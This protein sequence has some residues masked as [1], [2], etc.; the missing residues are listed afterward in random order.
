MPVRTAAERDARKAH[1]VAPGTGG[2][3]T[4]ALMIATAMQAFDATIANVALP[5]LEASLSGGIELGAWVM[6]SYLCASAVVA[7]LTGWVRHRYGARRLFPAAIALYALVSLGCSIA[8]SA[9]VLILF[10]ILQG[11]AGGLILPLSQAILLDIHPERE[12][13]RVLGMWG[14]TV[15]IGPILGPVLGGV[16]TDLASWRW[17]FAVNLPLAALA[18][19]GLRGALPPSDRAERAPIDWIGM[20]LLTVGVG[21]LEFGILRSIGI[22]ELLSPETI[23]E[24]M[25]GVFALSV[26]TFRNRLFNSRRPLFQIEIFSDRNFLISASY[27]FVISGLLFATIVFLP[28]LAQGP[29]GFS[30]TLAGLTIVPRGVGTMLMMLASGRLMGVVG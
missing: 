21:M 19:F 27:N 17:I 28:A 8:P 25:I 4:M 30:S 14:A 12:H 3:A 15:M 9:E 13:G 7:P 6:T 29:L 24:T 22:P 2:R 16:I 11:A 10:R 5:Q 26:T 18:I 20:V 1:S 23:G